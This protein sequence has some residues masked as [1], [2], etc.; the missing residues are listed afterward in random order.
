MTISEAERYMGSQ[1]DGVT[2]QSGVL[3]SPV[4]MLTAENPQ[5]AQYGPAQEYTLRRWERGGITGVLA[6]D[7]TGHVVGKW[8]WCPAAANTTR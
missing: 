8:S 1:P 2:D 5:S 4:M 7:E 6:F 3:V